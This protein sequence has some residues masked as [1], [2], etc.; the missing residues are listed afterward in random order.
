MKRTITA[1]LAIVLC[2]GLCA[3][4]GKSDNVVAVENAISAIGQV[5][6]DSGDV[7]T[8]AE[9]LYNALTEDEKSQ[10]ENAAQLTTARNDFDTLVEERCI[11]GTTIELPEYVLSV[12]NK[13]AWV[14]DDRDDFTAYNFWPET[15]TYAKQGFSEY[16]EHIAERTEITEIDSESFS[17]TA[18]DGT[19]IS[20]YLHIY[21]NSATIQVRV[22]KN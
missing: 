14:V 21:S 12:P 7:I 15:E 9:A 6:L 8:E 16:K 5:T 2:L 19:Q 11:P 18:D 20:V 22:P 4:G 13:G 17:F 1:L 10:V 3:C